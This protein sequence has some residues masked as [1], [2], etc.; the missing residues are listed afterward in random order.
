MNELEDTLTEAVEQQMHAYLTAIVTGSNAREWLY[1]TRT[2]KGFMLILNE[3]L[4]RF[5]P[6][7]IKIASQSD[8]DWKAYYRLA[9]S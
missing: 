5:P 3:A 4:S 1:Y 2:Q 6:L 7:P 9:S 8:P